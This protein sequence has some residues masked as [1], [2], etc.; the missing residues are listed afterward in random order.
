MK[1]EKICNLMSFVG[2]KGRE[3]DLTFQWQTMKVGTGEERQ[4][5]N[6]KDVLERVAGKFK[7]HLEAKMNPINVWEWE[8]FDSFIT[9]LQLLV[10]GLDSQTS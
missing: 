8:M 2:K 5:V 6:A 1:K 4:D 10:R 9:D 7:A 3:I